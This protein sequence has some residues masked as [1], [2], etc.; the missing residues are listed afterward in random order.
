MWHWI[1][2]SCESAS[3]EKKNNSKQSTIVK[4][5]SDVL[6]FILIWQIASI[7]VWYLLNKAIPGI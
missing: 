1:I 5:S 2:V 3:C 6:K 4:I 7:S